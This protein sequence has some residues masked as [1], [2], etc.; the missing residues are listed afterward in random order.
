MQYA[1]PRSL[2]KAYKKSQGF[3]YSVNH[4]M[5]FSTDAKIRATNVVADAMS[6][7]DELAF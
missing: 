7:I 6:C 2:E 3:T 1:A 5:Q 4:L